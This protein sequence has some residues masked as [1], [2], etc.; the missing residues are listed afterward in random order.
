MLAVCPPGQGPGAGTLWFWVPLGYFV[1]AFPS[2]LKDF[3]LRR[4]SLLV[5]KSLSGCPPEDGVVSPSRLQI[6]LQDVAF[7]GFFS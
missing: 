7:F 3:T 6:I 1:L 4:A 2:S 5:V